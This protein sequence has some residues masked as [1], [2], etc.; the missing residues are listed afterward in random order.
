MRRDNVLLSFIFEC[1]HD[2]D[3]KNVPARISV[4]KI[5]RFQNLPAK[6]CAVFLRTGGLSVTIFTVFK[7][8]RHHVKA[9]LVYDLFL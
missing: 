7:I 2:A 8:C 9:V 5:Y 6:K 3:F 4:F 1:S